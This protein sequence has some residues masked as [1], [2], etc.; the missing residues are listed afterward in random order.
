L[1][2]TGEAIGAGG[3]GYRITDVFWTIAGGE[4]KGVTVIG[5]YGEYSLQTLPYS[6]YLKSRHWQ[7]VR[8]RALVRAGHACQLCNTKQATLDV[9]HRTYERRGNEQPEDLIVLCRACHFKFHEDDAGGLPT[10]EEA[11]R[12]Y[13]EKI[14]QSTPIIAR[15]IEEAALEYGIET[16]I[17]AI[18]VADGAGVR[19]WTYI[20]GVL[21]NWK[22][23]QAEA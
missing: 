4:C 16:V 7:R 23:Q 17:R 8:S 22:E 20:E 21:R 18:G 1:P 19:K 12:L 11:L 14:G 6:I 15:M 9:H 3:I 5:D 13:G 10:V 2:R